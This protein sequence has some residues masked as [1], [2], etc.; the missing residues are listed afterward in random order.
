MHFYHTKSLK[1]RNSKTCFFLI[2]KPKN[3]Y[4]FQQTANKVISHSIWNEEN[5]IERQK[6]SCPS[7]QLASIVYI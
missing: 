3:A 4:F 6:A 7:R 2:F 1:K 5:D